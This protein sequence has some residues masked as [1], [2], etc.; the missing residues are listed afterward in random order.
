MIGCHHGRFH[1]PY[2]ADGALA[3]I[4][5]ASLALQLML[6]SADLS[7]IDLLTY[8]VDCVD[9]SLYSTVVLK[10]R[11]QTSASRLALV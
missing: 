1:D 9:Y 8:V 7:N 6:Y 10:F 11:V 4:C 2:A 5:I 3:L